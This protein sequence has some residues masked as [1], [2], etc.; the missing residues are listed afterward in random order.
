[1]TPELTYLAWTALLTASLWLPYVI[2]QG[3][4]KGLLTPENYRNATSHEVPAWGK[5]ANRVH[6]NAVEAFAP[7]AALVLVVQASSQNNATTAL[8][9][10]VFFWMRLAHA[11]VYLLGL[12][13]IRTVIYTIAWIA[14]VVLFWQIVT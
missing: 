9:C 1:M 6:L 10:A 7:F 2:A 13:Y 11:V 14:E 12:P 8:A 3:L 5:R 4:S